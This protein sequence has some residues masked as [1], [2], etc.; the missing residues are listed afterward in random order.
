MRPL[1][2]LLTAAQTCHFARAAHPCWKGKKFQ[3]RDKPGAGVGWAPVLGWQERVG[4]QQRPCKAREQSITGT[5]LREALEAAARQSPVCRGDTEP[6]SSHQDL[7]E[8]ENLHF[9][10]T[11]LWSGVTYVQ[12]HSGHLHAWKEKKC[13][14]N[15]CLPSLRRQPGHEKEQLQREMVWE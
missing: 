1:A 8:M 13:N 5:S 3:L 12:L 9:L 6:D 14:I 2:P 10:I 15:H 11:S 7:R 4:G